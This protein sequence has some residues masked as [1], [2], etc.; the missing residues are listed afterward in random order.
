MHLLPLETLKEIVFVEDV[1]IVILSYA[2]SFEF[3]VKV[4]VIP[5]HLIVA[6][7]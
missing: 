2:P 5:L 7:T 4:V 3:L 6:E 1:S